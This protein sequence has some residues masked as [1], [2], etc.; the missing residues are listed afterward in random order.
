MVLGQNL[1]F[2]LVVPLP[3]QPRGVLLVRRER[4]EGVPEHWVAAVDQ[5]GK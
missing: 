3:E 4:V 2:C 5:Q 1:S